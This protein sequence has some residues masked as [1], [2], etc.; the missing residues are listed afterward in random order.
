MNT[1]N[2]WIDQARRLLDALHAGNGTAGNSSAGNSSAGGAAS[3]GHGADCRWCPVCAV[4]AVV[5]GER[6]ELTAAL[7]D[8]LAATATA[9]RSF[10][11]EPEPAAAPPDPAQADQEE[12]P[13]APPVA[14]RIDIA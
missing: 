10:A 8:V 4:A 12:E 7:A 2:E 1:G 9:L 13:G 3:A 11:G 5:R 14:Q 6:P